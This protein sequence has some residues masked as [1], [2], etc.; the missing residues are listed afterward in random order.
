MRKSYPPGA[1]ATSVSTT[2]SGT[3]TVKA[4]RGFY[5]KALNVGLTQSGL[6][7]RLLVF[8]GVILTCYLF[9]LKSLTQELGRLEEKEV[10]REHRLPA[11]RTPKAENRKVKREDGKQRR[12]TKRPVAEVR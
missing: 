8:A 3:R 12:E 6:K 7:Q 10:E 9:Y 2:K 1:M 11:V 4:R 5:H